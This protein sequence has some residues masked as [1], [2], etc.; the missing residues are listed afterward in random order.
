MICSCAESEDVVN[1][2]A[3]VKRRVQISRERDFSFEA[4]GVR[5][6]GWGPGGGCQ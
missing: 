2:G 3:R 6:V 5:S 1:S 4:R